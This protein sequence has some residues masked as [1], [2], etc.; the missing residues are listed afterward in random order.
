MS[1]RCTNPRPGGNFRSSCKADD[2]F[3]TAPAVR[4]SPLAR[5]GRPLRTPHIH[6]QSSS[7]GVRPSK[8]RRGCWSWVSSGSRY[9]AG[10]GTRTSVCAH[11]CGRASP[12]TGVHEDV[13]S[14]RRRS[15][16]AGLMVAGSVS[17]LQA[18]VRVNKGLA[19]RG[20][21][22]RERIAHPRLA[23][24]GRGVGVRAAEEAVDV[25]LD[26]EQSAFR[27][28]QDLVVMTIGQVVARPQEEPRA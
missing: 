27:R 16:G 5:D 1:V 25:A 21:L 8:S 12:S 19:S 28:C 13:F 22:C 6:V 17:N 7:C 15:R 10:T 24:Q 20:W 11:R 3:W 2:A 23:A 4:C 18:P 9:A 26:G 14:S